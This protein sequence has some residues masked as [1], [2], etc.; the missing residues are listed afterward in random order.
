ML[1]RA[2]GG[3]GP[4]GMAGMAPLVE[5]RWL[6]ILRPLLA[7]PPARAA[8]GAGVPPG[9]DVGRGSVECRSGGAAAAAAA[10]AAGSRRRWCRD[11]RAGCRGC[12]VAA[13]SGLSDEATI[14]AGLAER[15][16]LRPEGFAVLSEGS[17][18]AAGLAARDRRRLPVRRFRRPRNSVA[19]L[20]AA[21][22][23]ATLAGVRLLPAGGWARIGCCVREAPP[24]RRQFRHVAGAVWDGR[25]RLVAPRRAAGGRDAGRLGCRCGPAAP[26]FG[27]AV[28]R[29][30]HTAGDPAGHEAARR[31]ASGLP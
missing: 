18:T 2:L 5:Q 11:R 19:R 27:A 6:R 25:F 13:G 30:A 1:I 22:R 17:D 10:A 4:A 7:V 15:V 31:A 29:A 14:A 28:R 3:S 24:W 8:R 12:G 9:I 20:A 23:P 16:S 21:P 26:A